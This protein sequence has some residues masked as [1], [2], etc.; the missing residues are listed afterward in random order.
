MAQTVHLWLAI[1]G[2][3]IEGESTVSSLDREDT[4]E[5]SSFYYGVEVPLD[6]S[7]G[8]MYDTSSG[9]MYDT[10]SGGMTGDRRHSAVKI[11]KRI[12]KSTPLLLKALC[13]NEPVSSAEFRFYRPSPRDGRVEH[14]YTVLLQGGFIAGVRQVSEAPFKGGV[15][16]PP[17]MEEVVF[18]FETITWT[19]EHGR[20]TYEDSRR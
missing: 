15:E 1:D 3:D 10:S 5:C 16:A 6:A 9:G 18:V 14:Y 11:Q 19:Y 20:V 7:S 4:I 17:M 12:D 13:E 2:V 8:G